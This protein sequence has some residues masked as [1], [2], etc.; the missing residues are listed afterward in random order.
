MNLR[1]KNNANTMNQLVDNAS[2]VLNFDLS[3][4]LQD[5]FAVPTTETIDSMF[6]ASEEDQVSAMEDGNYGLQL[7]ST[8]EVD[9]TS[10]DGFDWTGVANAVKDIKMPEQQALPTKGVSV[11]VAGNFTPQM[12]SQVL[13]TRLQSP[14]AL[15][16]A[17]M[18]RQKQLL[19][20]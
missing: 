20:L 8:K 7:D 19:G 4:V 16:S 12:Q 13:D 14:D 6:T 10:K 9:T 3:A 15:S 17:I 2:D 1:Q 18:G 5:E 11:N